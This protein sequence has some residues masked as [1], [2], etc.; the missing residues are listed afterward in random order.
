MNS[1]KEEKDKLVDEEDYN[2][3]VKKNYF[4]YVVLDDKDKMIFE[5]IEDYCLN[6][7]DF[8]ASD[9]ANESFNLNESLLHEM[10]SHLI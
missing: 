7:I 6:T 4:H 2:A 5:H 9:V 10:A 3:K 8:Y 1:T